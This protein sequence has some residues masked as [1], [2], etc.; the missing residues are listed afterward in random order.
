MTIPFLSVTD[1]VQG[2]AHGPFSKMNMLEMW[3][4]FK[5]ESRSKVII[6]FARDL[7]CSLIS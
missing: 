5:G 4:K 6:P 3:S 1:E 2:K 7:Q